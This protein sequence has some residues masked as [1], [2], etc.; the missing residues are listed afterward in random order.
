LGAEENRAAALEFLEQAWMNGDLTAYERFVSPDQVLHLAGYPEPFRGRDEALAWIRT[1]R[2]AFPEIS[3][4]IEAVIAE[5][6]TVALRWRSSQTHRGE[7]LGVKPLGTRVSMTA[8]Q[9]FRFGDDGL[10]AEVWILFDPLN[11]MQQLGVFPPGP[12]PKP[13][14]A[15]INTIR[16]LRR[17]RRT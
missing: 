15:V 1:Y 9:M 4:E 3:F 17:R 16:R 5:G 7:Y 6:D 14:L 11:V 2:S 13:L 10:I 8:L 12:L